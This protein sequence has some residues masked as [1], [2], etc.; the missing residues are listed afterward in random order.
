M[1]TNLILVFIFFVIHF[2]L[3]KNKKK[4]F[5]KNF[6]DIPNEARKIHKKPTYTIGGHF[7]FFAYIM[8]MLFSFDYNLNEKIILFII[9]SFI[10]LIGIFDDLRDL[11]PVLKL[12]LVLVTYFILFLLDNEYLLKKIYFE[13][14]NK[15]FY[16]GDFSFIISSLCIL[17]L[18]NAIN[19]MDGIN[20]LAIMTFTII[21]S[22]LYFYLNIQFNAYIFMVLVFIFFNIYRGRYFLGNSGSL[23]IG[24]LIGFSTIKAYN[25][26]FTEM[27]SAEDIFILFLIPGLDMLRLFLQRSLNKKNP[28]KADNMHLHHLLIKEFSLPK[29][30]FIYFF[31]IITSSYLAFNDYLPEVI[32]IIV[33]IIIYFFS[34]LLLLKKKNRK[35]F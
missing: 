26:N 4:I 5:V 25:L 14:F 22:F 29:V 20:G 16:F 13:T 12:T 33:I 6:L 7:I 2:I 11:K 23:I 24:A 27:N 32:I 30:L 17:L 3:D 8:F 35:F 10:F 15:V 34:L 21:C 1:I 18:V 9:F 31:L 19:L 28:F